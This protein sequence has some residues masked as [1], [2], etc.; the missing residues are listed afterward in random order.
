MPKNGSYERDYSEC[1]LARQKRVSKGMVSNHT[2][3]D[4]QVSLVKRK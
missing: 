3:S 2:R 1:Q 4:A